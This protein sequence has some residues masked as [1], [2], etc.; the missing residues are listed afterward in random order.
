MPYTSDLIDMFDFDA[1]GDLTQT[2]VDFAD[3]LGLTTISGAIQGLLD[4]T[5]AG[6]FNMH[7][8]IAE[9]EGEAFQQYQ[10]SLGDPGSADYQGVNAGIA[11]ILNTI[12]NS[13]VYQ[14][15][16]SFSPSPSSVKK[17]LDWES[18]WDDTYIPLIGYDSIENILVLVKGANYSE[19]DS[20]D[21]LVYN[22]TTGAW[23]KGSDKMQSGNDQSNMI[24]APNTGELIVMNITGA[25]AYNL[26]TF[27]AFQPA[28][29]SGNGVSIV[30]PFFDFGSSGNKK[31]LYKV[32]VL[33]HGPAISN[34]ALFASYDGYTN[35]YTDIF[36]GSNNFVNTDDS[37][38]MPEITKVD[39]IADVSDSLDQTSFNITGPTG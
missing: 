35:T 5:G 30:T 3:E 16:M 12:V 27:K 38:P 25:A 11:Q 10:A 7:Q 39:C 36:D 34:L 17:V 31:R 13:S 4:G 29:D 19:D 1:S 18:F 14:S 15:S 37:D 20:K 26:K 6:T 33:Y 8:A 21:I 23:T 24:V 2:D 32:K 22:F 28:T 9:F